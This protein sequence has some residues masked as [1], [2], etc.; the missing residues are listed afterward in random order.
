MALLDHNAF[1]TFSLNI[2]ARPETANHLIELQDRVGLDVNLALLCHWC[3]QHRSF[4][5]KTSWIL[6]LRTSQF[7]QDEILSP[8]RNRRRREKD[9]PDYEYFKRQELA[10]ERQAQKALIAALT[11]GSPATSETNITRYSQ[12]LGLCD[13]QQQALMS[14]LG[15][16]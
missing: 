6:M 9:S 10:L 16:P 15:S 14:C 13:I 1:W 5:H 11:G 4:P 12:H 8:Y 3:D 7:W 2:Y